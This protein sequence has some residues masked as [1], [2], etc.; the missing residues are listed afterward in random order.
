MMTI[1]VSANLNRSVANV[2]VHRS[3]R[4]KKTVP[5][6]FE[7][8]YYPWHDLM[9]DNTDFLGDQPG[10]AWWKRAGMILFFRVD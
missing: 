8:F 5:C 10:K 6:F 4:V 1:P 7:P 2:L 3:G 9:V